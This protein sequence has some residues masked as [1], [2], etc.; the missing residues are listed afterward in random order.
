V[1]GDEVSQAVER[2]RE[3]TKERGEAVG[4]GVALRVD[5][6]A[7]A[8]APTVTVNCAERMPVCH[9]ICC[10]LDFALTVDEVEAGQVK[11]DLGRPYQI[12]HDADGFCTHRHRRLRRLHPSSGR[13]SHV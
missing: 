2:V 1:S 8:E 6:P 3:E 7:E 12:R 10:K 9:S 5:G 4:V 11:W 13:L